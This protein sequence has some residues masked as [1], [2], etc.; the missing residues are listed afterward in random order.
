M[1]G[2]MKQ[3]ASLSVENGPKRAETEGAVK[4]QSVRKLVRF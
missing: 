4:V 1:A 2:Q 3:A